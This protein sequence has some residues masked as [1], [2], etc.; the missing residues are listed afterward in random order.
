M[1]FASRFIAGIDANRTVKDELAGAVGKQRGRRRI[2]VTDLVNPRQAFFRRTRLD[3]QPT[4]ERRQLM[5]SGSGFH[6]LF[7]SRV[8]THEFV[9]QFVEMDGI[10]G[11]IDVY[12]DVP[13]ELKT[14]SFVPDDIGLSRPGYIDQLAMY[15]AMTRRSN[16]RLIIYKRAGRSQPAALKAFDVTYRD[17]NAIAEDMLIRRDLL[18]QALA[19]ADPSLL[20]RCEWFEAGC[21]YEQVCG[22][23]EEVPPSRLV[24]PEAVLVAENRE[25]PAALVSQLGRRRE[26]P[27]QFRLND[28]VFPRK[29]ALERKVASADAEGSDTEIDVPLADLERQGFYGALGEA[30]RFGVP[31]AF[32]RIPVSLRDLK[33]WVGTYRGVPT[34]IRSTRLADMLDSAKVPQVFGHYV[35]RLA[36]ECALSGHQTGRIVVYYQ[37]IPD[38]KFM[39]YELRFG[40]LGEVVAEAD[41]RLGLL[42][43]GAPPNEM[44]PCPSWMTKF[45][46]YAPACGCGKSAAS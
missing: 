26:L 14:T 37:S 20:P 18:Q 4:P 24:S 8:S 29:A 7:G 30:L 13:T 1:G 22:C 15:C 19:T 11:K 41:R 27:P 35:D 25:L 6:E 21:D 32:S 38:D 16:G 45:C 46:S 5:L 31:G 33:G 23:S 44:P 2:S 9:E 12:E 17:L 36:F 28:L 39:V 3:I 40:S 10:V 43:A 42:E 34:I